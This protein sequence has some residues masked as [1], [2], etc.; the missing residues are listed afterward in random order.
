MMPADG[1]VPQLRQPVVKGSFDKYVAFS[2][3]RG[4]AEVPSRKRL[5]LPPSVAV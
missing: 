4:T 5:Q 3:K 1:Q 2:K